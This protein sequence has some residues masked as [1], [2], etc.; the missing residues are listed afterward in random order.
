M[1]IISPAKNLNI[2]PE[3]YSVDLTRPI[4]DKQTKKIILLLK[5]MNLKDVKSFLKVSDSLAKV[6]FQRINDFDT[7]DNIEKPAVFLFSGDTFNG[8]SIRSLDKNILE[9]A[10]KKLRILSG[11]Y[12]ILRPF[13][14]IQ[15]YR[16]EMGTN[17]SSLLGKSLTDFWKEKI[18]QLLNDD[19]KR[20]NSK[21]LFNLSSVE[22]FESIDK[23]RINAKL[24]NFDFK[25]IKNNEVS[26]IGMM[27]KKCRGAMARFIIKKNISKLD[28][29]K[30][31]NDLNFKFHS[32]D[33]SSN[34]FLFIVP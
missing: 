22:Y 17:I 15:P 19:I 4:L 28:D 30:K 26:N 10:Q 14:I 8:L 27:I 34:K 5:K 33:E 20:D 32:F 11:L 9:I 1:I 31:F 21:F 6:N 25:K 2:L 24:I 7:N 23:N 16:L 13:D 12:G 3:N 29:I 18:T